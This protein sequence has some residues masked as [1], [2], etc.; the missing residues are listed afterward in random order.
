MVY[1][2][3]KTHPEVL[4]GLAFAEER[5]REGGVG[6]VVLQVWLHGTELI[7]QVEVRT[8]RRRSRSVLSVMTVG[9]YTA[10]FPD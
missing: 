8:A 9:A 7:L 2:G 3:S 5:L 1:L 6:R 4:Q 10:R